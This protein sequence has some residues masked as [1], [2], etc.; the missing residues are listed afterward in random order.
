MKLA[1]RTA[2]ITGAG[3]GIGRAAAI[4]A[5]RRGMTVA[6]LGRRIERLRETQRAIGNGVDHLVIQA[7]VTDP[8]ARRAVRNQV[9]VRWGHLDVLV[10]CAGIVDAGPLNE[11]DD[12]ALTRLV[13][14]NVVAPLALTRELCPLLRA[15]SPSRVV[16]VGS[17]L[18]DIAY[19]LFSA[20]SASK[21]ALRGL[22]NALRRELQGF[23]VGVTLVSPRGAQTET[24]AAI[25]RFIEPMGMTL[26]EPGEI[27][28]QLW[29]AV[30]R[31]RDNAYP[32]L[33]ER[34]YVLIERLFPAI[35]DNALSVQM[36][37]SGLS[38]FIQQSAQYEP[39]AMP[40]S[41]PSNVR[42]QP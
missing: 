41:E 42:N 22:S 26:D 39:L 36:A 11:I 24:T 23:D 15:A 33:R 3:S 37:T 20:Y 1:G 7:D 40:A 21:F 14:T 5:A 34:L 38:H 16:N 29:N 8:T 35:I 10:N 31:G 2:L 9:A 12:A 18:G 17:M 6:L 4:E 32:G 19:P 28:H 27:A 25:A 13:A 30:E